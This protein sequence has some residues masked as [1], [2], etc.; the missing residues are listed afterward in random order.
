[1]VQI[2]IKYN[3]VSESNTGEM[4]VRRQAKVGIAPGGLFIASYST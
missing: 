4:L 2:S 3:F 1:M